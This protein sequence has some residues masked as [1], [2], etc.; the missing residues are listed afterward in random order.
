MKRLLWLLLGLVIGVTLIGPPLFSDLYGQAANTGAP[1]M[2]GSMQF[3]DNNGDPLNAGTVST[4][5]TGTSTSAVTYDNQTLNSRNANPIVLN[6]AGRGTIFLS[7]TQIYRFIVSDSSNVILLTT[8]GVTG[9]NYVAEQQAME[10]GCDG[11]LTL[12]SG[13][14]VTTA[15]VTNATTIYLT[16][17]VGNRCAL[18]DGTNW[19][20]V[21]FSEA[22][23]SLGTEAAN[24][25]FDLFAYLVGTTLTLESVDWAN[26]YDRQINLTRQNGVLVRS[27]AVTR[28][29]LGTYR[30]TATIGE[31]EDSFERRLVW[32]VAHRVPR[33]M[34]VLDDTNTW[35]YS[36]NN[37]RQANANTANLLSFVVGDTQLISASA[38]AHASNPIGDSL[39]YTAIGDGTS[40][41]ALARSFASV[42]ETTGL[43]RAITAEVQDYARI[44]MHTWVWLERASGSTT[45]TWRGDDADVLIQSGISGVIEGD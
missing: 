43:V 6:S 4:Y 3:F 37:Y 17:Y 32:N 34:R 20:H 30:T 16:P 8:D 7:A 35:T 24:T 42:M 31:T 38:R 11:R 45:T 14:P 12:T 18:Y 25:N 39:A 29:Y 9:S 5:V 19:R 2:M 27:N 22:S 1:A 10:L 13:V 44:G 28:R 15:S 21:T 36:T 33:L 41:M 40:G 23:W 26:Q